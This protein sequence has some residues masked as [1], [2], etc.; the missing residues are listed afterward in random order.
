MLSSLVLTWFLRLLVVLKEIFSA[1]SRTFF[2]SMFAFF[3]MMRSLLAI[4]VFFNRRSSFSSWSFRSRSF[5]AILSWKSSFVR[6]T[7]CFSRSY[8]VLC[9]VAIFDASSEFLSAIRSSL[10]LISFYKFAI[11]SSHSSRSL[12]ISSRSSSFCYSREFIPS[13][14]RLIVLIT[15]FACPSTRPSRPTLKNSQSLFKN[16]ISHCFDLTLWLF[17]F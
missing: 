12:A 5:V 17:N 1:S 8:A 3:S 7:C 2:V 9:S 14:G 4:A 11:F 15:H 13:F 6:S 16:Y 10:S